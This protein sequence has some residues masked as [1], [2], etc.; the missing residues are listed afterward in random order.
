MC[1]GRW[2]TRTENKRRAET[3]NSKRK[4]KGKHFKYITFIHIS[5]VQRTL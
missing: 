2:K 1:R 5:F 3:E 4:R